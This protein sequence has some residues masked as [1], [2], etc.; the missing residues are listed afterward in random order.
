MQNSAMLCMFCESL[1]KMHTVQSQWSHSLKWQKHIAH[2]T[3]KASRALGLLRH[4]FK[5]TQGN[6]KILHTNVVYDL[7]WNTALSYGIPTSNL[8]FKSLS[9]CKGVLCVFP[10]IS[11]R[12]YL[13]PVKNN[14]RGNQLVH[15]DK[16]PVLRYNVK[17]STTSQT[18]A[19]YK[20]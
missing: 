14:T 20:Y 11:N 2:A 17:D 4:N 1:L 7:S 12:E 10:A 6:I 3:N 16:A 13:K 5:F 18:T 8:I 15:Y 9:V 19:I